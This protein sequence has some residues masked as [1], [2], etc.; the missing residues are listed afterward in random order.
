[1][2]TV[3]SFA[4]SVIISAHASAGTKFPRNSFEMADLEKAKASAMTEKKTR[5]SS[6]PIKPPAAVCARKWVKPPSTR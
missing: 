4:F 2:S 3:V 5:P 6:L 1:M